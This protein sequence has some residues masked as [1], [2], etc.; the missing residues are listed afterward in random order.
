ML[1]AGRYSAGQVG[2]GGDIS[3]R[4]TD[5]VNDVGKSSAGISRRRLKQSL[6]K[7]IV[8]S[9]VEWESRTR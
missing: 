5:N 4:N 8:R 9:T 1:H 2:L 6:S 7:N 3:Y